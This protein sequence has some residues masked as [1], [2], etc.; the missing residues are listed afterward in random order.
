MRGED[1][2]GEIRRAGGLKNR[3]SLV[4]ALKT[5]FRKY[6]LSNDYVR[7]DGNEIQSLA[8]FLA[9]AIFTQGIFMYFVSYE[10]RNLRLTKAFRAYLPVFREIEK[11]DRELATHIR[12][13]TFNQSNKNTSSFEWVRWYGYQSNLIRFAVNEVH[14]DTTVSLKVK[15]S[16]S[17]VWHSHTALERTVDNLIK[18]KTYVEFIRDNVSSVTLQHLQPI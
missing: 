18:S 9:D 8:S 13:G 12:T 1:F 11:L 4:A 15:V 17:G 14:T 2:V 16:L 7:I 5:A 3:N 6:A 10:E